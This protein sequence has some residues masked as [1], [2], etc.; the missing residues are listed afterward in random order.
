MKSTKSVC[1]LFFIAIITACSPFG[2][3]YK[4]QPR[5]TLALP[6]GQRVDP[7]AV[8][9]RD[10]L[11]HSTINPDFIFV[12]A[13]GDS[14]PVGVSAE[15]DSINKENISTVM[16]DEI[17]VSS[18]SV[19][20][21]AERDGKINV[22]FVV[23]VPKELQAENWMVNIRPVLLKGDLPDS[24]KE[25]RF[26]GSKFRERQESDYRRYDR[27]L[28][29]IIPDSVNFYH[30]FVNYHAFER[31]LER[32][33]WYQRG[34]ER[35]WAIL[36]AKKRRPDRLLQRFDFF[37]QKAIRLDTLL[38]QRMQSDAYRMID[39]QWWQYNQASERMNDT[40]RYLN[41]YLPERF[42][43]FNMCADRL[44]DKLRNRYQDKAE[45][46]NFSLS[47]DSARLW[48]NYALKIARG[49]RKAEELIARK[50]YFYEQALQ[51]SANASYRQVRYPGG[52]N[53]E[54]Y[55]PRFIYFNEKM[56]RQRA[57]LYMHYRIK[58]ARAE[59]GQ[60]IKM[61]KALIAGKD[62]T[63][64]YLNRSQLAEKYT[65]RYQK[66]KDL[67]PMFHFRRPEA[68]TL[69][70]PW[71]AGTT[72]TVLTRR[73]LLSQFS[74][75][76]IYDYYR[77][78]IRPDTL[79]PDS[80]SIRKQYASRFNFFYNLLPVYT[81][82]RE[83]PDSAQRH[84]PGKK[85]VRDFK[86]SLFDS[87]S[88]INYYTKRYEHFRAVYPQYRFM[89]RLH[90]INPPAV[91]YAA[92]QEKIGKWIDR[93][94][95]L[96]SA[97][98]VK[99][100]YNTQK[101]A[102]NE[103][104][105]AMR[106]EK[107]RDIVRFPFNSEARLDTVIYAAGQVHFLY[108]ENIPADENS[109]RMKVYLTGD[110]VSSTGTRYPLPL[111]DTLTYLV[112]SMTKFVDESPRYVRKIVTRDAEANVSVDFTF[113]KNKF[114]LDSRIETNR[115]GLKKV[116]DLTLDLMTDP[117]YRIDSLT[118]FAASSP[119][120]NWRINGE[121]ARKRAESIRSVLERDF[122][123]LY[124]SLAINTSVEVDA[125]GKMV[126][127]EAADDIPDLPKLVKIRTIPE[128]WD[129]LTRLII[130]DRNFAG[131]KEA[132][133][134]LIWKENEPDRR[135]YLIRIRYP[136]EYAYMYDKLYPLVRSVDFHFS[137]SRKGMRQDTLYT[138]EPD[139]A[140]A[141]GVEYLKK[142]KYEQA[143]EILRPYADRN[144]ALAYMSLGYDK[145]ALRI[146]QTLPQLAEIKYLQAILQV[147][148][149]D[150][151]KAVLLLLGA[152]EMDEKMKFRA[153]LDPELSVLVKKY[154]LFQEDDF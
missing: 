51:A 124:D 14:V 20:N 134:K 37:N 70:P 79:L 143:L 90:N 126:Q 47:G 36:D 85:A 60:G 38:K 98:L 132:I 64:A 80:G 118:L 59:S 133:L 56:E 149:G 25:L 17:V 136:K 137:L 127:R 145:A 115:D 113:P 16:M 42:R 50:K 29:N 81:F 4:E 23:T 8:V 105:K 9:K 5:V 71:M 3:L 10:T 130:A 117:V 84:I 21:T 18:Q 66:I 119:E 2:R 153:N 131:N 12:T 94:S 65:K 55:Y 101:I 54:I 30:T 46:Q 32:L 97:S 135:E 75:K 148:L 103:A 22:E 142:R 121:I 1:I 99:M 26:T 58:G 6:A 107:F 57:S 76:D 144:T 102:R 63:S 11:V 112:S 24:L 39:R 19:R 49:N 28:E 67:L 95:S 128:D 35:R 104:R 13:T 96:D 87:T 91:K 123:V 62:T 147:R 151:K 93:I 40:V 74:E 7:L 41:K 152:A 100:F 109:S 68:D 122:A 77:K 110:V 78:Q 15:W 125:S 43:F 114:K 150:E 52:I 129:K 31:Y 72:D 146:Y 61:L 138:T 33:K 45:Y 69:S 53:P 88:T 82:R 27:F 83:I 111:S 106:D 89:R 154:G 116:R 92:R 108:S 34:L 139:T 44:T 73:M 120:G 140:Y 141:R 86:Y 48:S